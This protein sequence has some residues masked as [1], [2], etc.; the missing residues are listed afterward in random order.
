MMDE[1]T[2]KASC[3][4]KQPQ[5]TSQSSMDERFGGCAEG[6]SK[7]SLKHQDL[8]EQT[9]SFYAIMLLFS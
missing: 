5:I 3:T 9:P 1:W 2:Y 6:Q 4:E 8:N 7:T